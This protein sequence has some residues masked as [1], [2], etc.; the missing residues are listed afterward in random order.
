MFTGAKLR[1][2]VMVSIALVAGLLLAAIASQWHGGDRFAAV[3]PLSG[4]VADAGFDHGPEAGGATLGGAGA[5]APGR[6][7]VHV[8]AEAERAAASN[9]ARLGLPL[10][11]S[12]LARA[13]P[14]A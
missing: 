2:A 5:V 11:R 6:L 3:P 8:S 13:P 7:L 12:G 1:A 9:R 10:A 4:E 14:V